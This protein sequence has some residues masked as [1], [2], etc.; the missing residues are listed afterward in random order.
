MKCLPVGK[1]PDKPMSVSVLRSVLRKKV[2]G[3][4]DASIRAFC[5]EKLS[6]LS[7]AKSGKNPKPFLSDC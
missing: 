3:D 7:T 6:Q 4:P 1:W 2:T 5:R